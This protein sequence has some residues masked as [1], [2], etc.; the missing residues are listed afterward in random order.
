MDSPRVVHEGGRDLDVRDGMYPWLDVPLSADELGRIGRGAEA[1]RST[2]FRPPCL[3]PAP[4]S[5]IRGDGTGGARGTPGRDARAGDRVAGHRTCGTPGWNACAEEGLAGAGAA[6]RGRRAS[7]N[8]G[9]EEGLAGAGAAGRGR[10]ASWN[11]GAEQGLT[12]AGA[13]ATGTR[14]RARAGVA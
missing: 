11:A 12:G 1:G 13:R 14:R 4:G 9:A 7:W 3:T 10:R 8:A 6:G 2:T 5:C